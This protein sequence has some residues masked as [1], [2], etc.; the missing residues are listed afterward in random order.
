MSKYKSWCLKVSLTSEVC[1]SFFIE[2][3]KTIKPLNTV[4]IPIQESVHWPFNNEMAC[5][6][7]SLWNLMKGSRIA[8]SSGIQSGICLSGNP[9]WVQKW[10]SKSRNSIS[11]KILD[12]N[13]L[14]VWFRQACAGLN[15]NHSGFIKLCL[16]PRP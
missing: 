10:P 13:V 15:A 5:F 1:A 7:L 2:L 14:I 11:K 16:K 8:S 6:V 4:H 12:L 3:I 9:E